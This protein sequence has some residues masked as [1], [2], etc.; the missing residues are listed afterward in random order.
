MPS[1]MQRG[2]CIY[3]DLLI[4]NQKGGKVVTLAD[5]K[6]SVQ[7]ELGSPPVDC[8][9]EKLLPMEGWFHIVG[10]L[11]NLKEFHPL[12]TAKFN[13]RQEINHELAFNW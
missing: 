1:V 4:N 13:V 8:R 11:Y 3:L 9:M 2:M 10:K 12:K 7:G 5:Q 6:I